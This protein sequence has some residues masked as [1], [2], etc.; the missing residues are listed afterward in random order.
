[1]IIRR[2]TRARNHE[3]LSH[4][5]LNKITEWVKSLGADQSSAIQEYMFEVRDYVFVF[6]SQI[7]RVNFSKLLQLS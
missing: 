5:V 3:K 1:M 2:N 7:P 6:I 4:F